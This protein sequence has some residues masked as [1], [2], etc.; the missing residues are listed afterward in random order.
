MLDFPAVIDATDTYDGP[1]MRPLTDGEVRAW[2]PDA[3]PTC[4]DWDDALDSGRLTFP[5]RALGNCTVL[6]RN[7]L[8]AQIGYWGT[9][10]D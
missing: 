1:F 4:A 5:D 2:A 3:R 10:A 7:G 8:P 9:T 6:Y